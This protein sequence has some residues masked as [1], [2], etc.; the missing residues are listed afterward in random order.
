MAAKPKDF[1]SSV[2]NYIPKIK[3]PEGHS[4]H[5][6][7]CPH[8]CPDTC[9]MLVTRNDKTGKAVSVQG[10]PSHPITK[11][12]LCNKV[13]HYID[14]LLLYPHF[15]FVDHK[16]AIHQYLYNLLHTRYKN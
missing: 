2:V 8:D 4:I 12:Y 1:S 5:H 14:L 13:N 6:V 16:L 7:C 9:S 11:G 15:L 10:D 3:P